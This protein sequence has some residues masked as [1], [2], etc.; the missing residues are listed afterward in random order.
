MYVQLIPTWLFVALAL[1][2]LYGHNFD[3]TGCCICV[4]LN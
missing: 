2:R 3:D 4:W 1:E